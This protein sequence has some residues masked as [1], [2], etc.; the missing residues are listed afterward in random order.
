MLLARLVDL[1]QRNRYYLR[2]KLLEDTTID[3][4]LPT[5]GETISTSLS[6]FMITLCFRKIMAWL[7]TTN[8]LG[9]FHH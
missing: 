5:I 9:N 4:E 6:P 1:L 3:F 2:I 8:L 7:S